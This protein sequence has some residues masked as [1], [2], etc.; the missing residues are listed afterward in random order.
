MAKVHII[1]KNPPPSCGEFI[2][3]R[4]LMDADTY[5]AKHLGLQL[6]ALFPE[7]SPNLSLCLCDL[8]PIPYNCPPRLADRFIYGHDLTQT[9]AAQEVCYR[10]FERGMQ[11]PNTGSL[12][13]LV[14]SYVIAKAQ[15][16]LRSQRRV[17]R[18]VAKMDIDDSRNSDGDFPPCKTDVEFYLVNNEDGKLEEVSDSS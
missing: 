10:L 5:T 11:G 14:G 16:A 3:N 13:V 1:A 18:F 15:R 12:G 8:M 9:L 6:E 17:I 4:H 2:L 7:L